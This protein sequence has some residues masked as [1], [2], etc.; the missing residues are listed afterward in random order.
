MPRQLRSRAWQPVFQGVWVYMLKMV[1]VVVTFVQIN[2]RENSMKRFLAVVVMAFGWL[3][4]A[5]AFAQTV[6]LNFEDGTSD[7]A[8]GSFYSAQG[9]TFSSAE[10]INHGGL[11]GGSGTL[12][13]RYPGSYQWG[14]ANPV[15][16]TFSTPV[17]TVSV[18]GLDIGVQGLVMTAYDAAAGG[19]QVA[20]QQV[21]GTEVGVGQFYTL[22]VAGANIRRVEISQLT[23]DGGDGI[24]LDDF[25][26]TRAAVAS[27]VPVPTLS[28]G[29][30]VVLAL[31]LACAAL[32]TRRRA[33]R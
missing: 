10:W 32:F 30:L 17:S 9:V 3:I 14:P 16:A 13:I 27:A 26:F 4:C 11:A 19:T 1:C 20:T 23:P 24:I 12:G 21:V 2:P 7:T 33:L 5:P 22:T 8:V 15:I 25:S 18:V 31:A 29:A 28:P 6:T